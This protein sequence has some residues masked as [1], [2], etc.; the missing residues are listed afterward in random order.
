MKQPHPNPRER[1]ALRRERDRRPVRR[2]RLPKDAITIS[3][4]D[5][6]T[7]RCA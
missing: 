1:H 6:G 3:A 5:T 4:K 7:K 2:V